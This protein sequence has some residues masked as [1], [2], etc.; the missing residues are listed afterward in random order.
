M[1]ERTGAVTSSFELAGRYG[2]VDADGHRPDWSAHFEKIAREPNY[3][4]LKDAFVREAAYLDR[5]ARRAAGYA[6]IRQ[7]RP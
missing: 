1:M 7:P 4:W 3:A 2:I 6:G 5:I